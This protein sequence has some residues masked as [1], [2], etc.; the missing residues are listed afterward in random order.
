MN[1]LLATVVRMN[2]SDLYVTAG[3]PPVIRY[4]GRIR[5]L[6]TKVLDNADTTALMNSITPDRYQH[7][8]HEVGGA[9]FEISF[10]DCRFRVAVFKQHGRLGMVLRRI[11][12]Q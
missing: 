12:N 5:R 8:I 6:D 1:E 3:Q 2:A 4:H 11:P 10:D 7:E 9:D